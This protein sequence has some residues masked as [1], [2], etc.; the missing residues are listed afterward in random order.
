M[1]VRVTYATP[2]AL[3]V[4]TRS[5]LPTGAERQI[6]NV[7]A[8]APTPIPWKSRLL[9][10]LWVTFQPAGRACWTCRTLLLAWSRTIQPCCQLVEETQ[11]VP[12]LD[13]QSRT[14]A[15]RLIASLRAS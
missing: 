6:V 8:V 15:F 13:A 10:A 9:A 14:T 11:L 1:V 4:T 3:T 7:V 5:C 2:V 12:L